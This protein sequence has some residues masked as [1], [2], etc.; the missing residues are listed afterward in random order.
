MNTLGLDDSN[1]PNGSLLSFQRVILSSRSDENCETRFFCVLALKNDL[2]EKRAVA[3]SQPRTR[4][5]AD[6]VKHD[7]GVRQRRQFDRR[8]G[9]CVDRQPRR[10]GHAAA[11]RLSKSR[12]GGGGGGMSG[13]WQEGKQK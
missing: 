12:S 6:A 9:A 11:V 1:M 2:K 3:E 8:G 13:W 4:R 5:R 10:V 7:E